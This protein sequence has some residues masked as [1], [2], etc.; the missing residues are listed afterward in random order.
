[1][2]GTGGGSIARIGEGQ[3]LRVGPQ[4]AGSMPGP[5]CY[6]RG[7]AEP[8]VTDANLL[9][10][11]IGAE[12]RLGEAITLRHEPVR[13]AVARIAEQFPGLSLEAAADGIVRIAVAKKSKDTP[14]TTK[15]DRLA[16]L[17]PTLL[18][19]ISTDPRPGTS[20]V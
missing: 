11:R 13:A 1:M 15:Q 19:M 9:L 8:T 17:R 14:I 3:S 5:A 10:G 6:G 2:V 16:V 12:R 7:G 20:E 18:L 4:S